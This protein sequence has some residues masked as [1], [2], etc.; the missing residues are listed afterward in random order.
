M[1]NFK[2]TTFTNLYIT[3]IFCV[4]FINIYAEEIIPDPI[5]NPDPIVTPDPII[6]SPDPVVDPVSVPDPIVI[7]TRP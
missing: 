3:A 2:S 1:Q 5:I 4:S 7:Q 6:V